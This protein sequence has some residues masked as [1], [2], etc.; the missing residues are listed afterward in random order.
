MGQKRWS[1]TQDSV[2]AGALGRHPNRVKKK[3]KL[4]TYLFEKSIEKYIPPRVSSYSVLRVYPLGEIKVHLPVGSQLS[5]VSSD[6]YRSLRSPPPDPRTPGLGR[7]RFRSCFT[8]RT[9][10]P[11]SSHTGRRSGPT[12]GETVEDHSHYPP[13]PET[14]LSSLPVPTS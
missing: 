4:L 14:L 11:L 13:P 3:K 12:S 5:L 8:G 10:H 6:S 9:H 7:N 1:E 2:K